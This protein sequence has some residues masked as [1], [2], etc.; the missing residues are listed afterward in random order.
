MNKNTYAVRGSKIINN[1]LVKKGVDR[2]LV[3]V[4][5]DK[6]A[7]SNPLVVQKGGGRYLNYY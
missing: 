5:Y 4:F 6:Q 1:K 7:N 3:K 2:Q